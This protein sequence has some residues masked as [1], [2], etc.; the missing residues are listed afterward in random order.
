MAQ[1]LVR[2]RSLLL[3]SLRCSDVTCSYCAISADPTAWAAVNKA[4]VPQFNGCTRLWWARNYNEVVAQTKAIT[5]YLSQ[6]N[7]AWTKPTTA[8][9][10]NIQYVPGNLQQLLIPATVLNTFQDQSYVE[11]VTK[12]DTDGIAALSAKWGTV[13][14][15]ALG[16][17]GT[18]QIVGEAPNTST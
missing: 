12:D 2:A 18:V 10:S 7:S 4:W 9:L 15:T 16:A 14:Y 3:T 11:C 13:D 6:F 1:Q 8:L 17:V 5:T